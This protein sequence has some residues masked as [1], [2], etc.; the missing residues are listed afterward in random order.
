MKSVAVFCGANDGSLPVYSEQARHLGGRLAEI[1]IR[2]V[3]GG[4][5][6]GIMGKV[7]EGALN[8]G[9]EVIGVIPSF[10]QTIEVAHDNLTEMLVVETMHERKTK[11]NELSEGIIALPGG[12][13][14]MEEFFEILTW[15]QLGLH[16]KPM[17]LLNIDGFYDSLVTQFDVMVDN[18]LLKPDNREMV[19]VSNNIDD[20]LDRMRQYKA[21]AVAKWITPQRT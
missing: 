2:V 5:K 6:I 14:T 12:F 18:K 13:G 20:L 21:P 8:A 19:L 9:G 7:A 10:L 17:G 11:M 3:Y 16:S 15:G 4:A 1:G